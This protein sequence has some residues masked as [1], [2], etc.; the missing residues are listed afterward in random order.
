MRPGSFRWATLSP[1]RTPGNPFNECCCLMRH[2]RVVKT[3]GLNPPRRDRRIAGELVGA[4]VIG[5]AGMALDP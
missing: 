4:F 5:M 3:S 2:L 1:I